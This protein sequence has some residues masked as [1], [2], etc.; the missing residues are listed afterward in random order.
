MVG[1][2][3][4]PLPVLSGGQ[5]GAVTADDIREDRDGLALSRAPPGERPAE[6]GQARSRSRRSNRASSGASCGPAAGSDARGG[7]VITTA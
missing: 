6:A 3:Q 7:L 4:L 1:V 2:S 5:A